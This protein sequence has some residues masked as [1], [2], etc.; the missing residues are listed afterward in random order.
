LPLPRR[1]AGFTRTEL[2]V[3][4]GLLALIFGLLIPLFGSQQEKAR[5][6]QCANN[7]RLIGTAIRAYAADH[8]NRIP[9]AVQNAGSMTWDAVLV[10][11]QYLSVFY[12]HCPADTYPRKV[13]LSPRTYAISCGESHTNGLRSQWIQGS[14]LD[15]AHFADPSQIVLVTERPADVE[16]RGYGAGLSRDNWC[17]QTQHFSAHTK[18]RS[19]H[20][21]VRYNRTM[22][23]LFLDGHVGWLENPS[24]EQRAMMF[25]P[26]P[27]KARPV[28]P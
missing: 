5:R 20:S 9:A 22:N 26:V 13:G 19:L 18:Q 10:S 27:G 2:L 8:S 16:G 17:D 6:S 7:L 21:S 23:Y 15:C 4:L 1:S 11:N 3:T 14:R 12:F 28:C 25:P 24:P